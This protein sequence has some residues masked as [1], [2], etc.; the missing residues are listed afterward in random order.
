MERD[1][2]IAAARAGD[3][4][5]LAE[6]MHQCRPDVRRYAQ[7]QCSSADVDDAVQDALWILHQ[8]VGAL[9]V[10]AA[11]SGW[12]FQVVKRICLGMHRRADRYLPLE[13]VLPMADERQQP[14]LQLQL[15]GVFARLDPE[16]RE[17]LL[18]RDVEGYTTEETARMLELSAMAVKSR[19]HRARASARRALLTGKDLS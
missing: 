11:F 4:S 12:L 7:R 2:L 16:H 19:L 5:A 10:V 18:L 3:G 1:E 8:R 13:D 17:I 15:A 6:L 9:R 14:E